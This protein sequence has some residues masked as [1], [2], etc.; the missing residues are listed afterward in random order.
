MLAQMQFIASLGSRPY[1]ESSPPPRARGPSTTGLETKKSGR[2]R[3][4]TRPLPEVMPYPFRPT[5]PQPTR[6]PKTPR[7]LAYPVHSSWRC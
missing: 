5:Q 2:G 1:R 6:R 3:A 7:C 4:P